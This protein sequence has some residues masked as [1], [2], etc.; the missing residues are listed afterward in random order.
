MK[1]FKNARLFSKP[2]WS[3]IISL[4]SSSWP[5]ILSIMAPSNVF[6]KMGVRLPALRVRFCTGMTDNVTQFTGSPSSSSDALKGWV[7]SF[8]KILVGVLVFAG[9]TLSGPAVFYF[10]G[11]SSLSGTSLSDRPRFHFDVCV[12]QR[13]SVCPSVPPAYYLE[14]FQQTIRFIQVLGGTN[15]FVASHDAVLDCN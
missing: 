12:I 8:T 2:R 15:S 13:L 1:L 14:N 10:P 6:S 9:C 11:C 7:K 5:S 4:P 3:T